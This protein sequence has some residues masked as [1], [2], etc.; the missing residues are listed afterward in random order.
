MAQGHHRSGLE[1]VLLSA[2]IEADFKGTVVDLGAGVGVAG[3][4]IA[5]RCAKANALLVER[6]PEAIACS[7]EALKRPANAP[8]AARVTVITADIVASETE[9]VAAGLGRGVADAVVMNPPF[10]EAGRGTA[11]PDSDRAAA[12]MLADVGLDR[13][14]RTAASVLKPSGRLVVIFRGDRLDGLLA[15][16]EGRFGGAAVLPIHPRAKTPAHR[17]LVRADKGSRAPLQILPAL[18]LHQDTG[19]GY[20]PAME[21]ILREGVGLAAVHPAWR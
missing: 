16:L 7:R 18:V 9:R 6:N 11:S 5:V 3:M 4:A 17:I 2:A 13:W 12:H 1:A 10:H 14:L 8:F 19:H 15:M 21:S 20:Q